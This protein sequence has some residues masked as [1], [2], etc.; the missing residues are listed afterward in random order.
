MCFGKFKR[1]SSW[2]SNYSALH[3]RD[4]KYY[5]NVL[6]QKNWHLKF[7]CSRFTFYHLL[8]F[9]YQFCEKYVKYYWFIHYD[10]VFVSI[11]NICKKKTDTFLY[12][13]IKTLLILWSLWQIQFYEVR[14]LQKMLPHHFTKIKIVEV[15]SLAKLTT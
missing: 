7:L 13:I 5:E 11:I 8:S 6:E 12:K 2:T 14:N 3:V 15:H 9:D 4:T 1:F 10:N